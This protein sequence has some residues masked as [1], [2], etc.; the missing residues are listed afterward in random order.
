M[1]PHTDQYLAEAAVV[2]ELLSV[3]ARQLIAQLNAFLPHLKRTTETL[4]QKHCSE[5]GGSDSE[6]IEATRK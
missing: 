2:K 4:I 3:K 5:D 1:T 6:G